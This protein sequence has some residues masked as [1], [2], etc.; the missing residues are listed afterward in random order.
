MD[1][2]F[3]HSAHAVDDAVFSSPASLLELVSLPRLT[4][5]LTRACHQPATDY[6]QLC[7][8][9]HYDPALV[10]RYLLVLQSTTTGP[11]PAS[12]SARLARGNKALLS[13][14]LL[15]SDRFDGKFTPAYWEPAEAF[16][17]QHWLE[18]VQCAFLSRA[19]ARVLEL[20]ESDDVFFAGLLYRCGEIALLSQEKQDYLTLLEQCNSAEDRRQRERALYQ[21]QHMWISQR[22][23]RQLDLPPAFRDATLYYH[24]PPSSIMAAHP[25]T[26]IVYVAHQITSGQITRF[27]D[28]IQLARTLLDLH[29]PHIEML[30]E[31]ALNQAQDIQE[32]L[33]LPIA[34]TQVRQT[35]LPPLPPDDQSP[36]LPSELAQL[37]VERSQLSRILSACTLLD[38]DVDRGTL[39]DNIQRLAFLLFGARSLMLFRHVPETGV[40]QGENTARP[41]AFETL[42]R[43]PL[44]QTCLPTDSFRQQEAIH[45]FHADPRNSAVVDLELMQLAGCTSLVALPLT[46]ENRRW[47]CMVLGFEPDIQNRFNLLHRGL[48]FF[49]QQI[50]NALERHDQR[51]HWQHELALFERKLFEHRLKRIA[52]EV[53]NPLS[54]AQNHLHIVQMN[55]A[56]PESARDHV[57]T[58]IEQIE[59]SSHILQDGI[60]RLE[61]LESRTVALNLNELITDLVYVFASEQEADLEFKTD[62]DE[63]L[64]A[65]YIDDNHLRQVLINL[66]KN[67]MECCED[68]GIIRVVTRGKIVINGRRH[69]AVHIQDDGPGIPD[70]ELETL[71]QT[72]ASNKSGAHAGIG[73]AIVRDLVETMGGLISFERSED[74]LSRFSIHLPL[75]GC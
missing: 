38:Q 71:F 74:E 1:T 28:A 27:H 52:H 66:I 14:T 59:S 55:E 34:A 46:R 10:V 36:S 65:I 39:Q 51:L 22:I 3:L 35:L 11:Q 20:P 5:Q 75:T 72:R 12:I 23:L 29:A 43:L 19:F 48:L 64:P 50:Q 58:V 32:T 17:L 67:A 26:R 42:L 8:L 47:G 7:Q 57:E 53:N 18:S 69:V 16:L 60:E 15:C 61:G 4:L 54:I 41:D 70:S 30:V 9:L 73:L 44:A 33:G 24:L 21:T 25:V 31:S 37:R 49:A 56:L 13:R 45:N 63:S 40:L 6:P 62:L 2:F 68:G